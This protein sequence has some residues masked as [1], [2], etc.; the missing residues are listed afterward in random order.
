[1]LG[2][3]VACRR[4]YRNNLDAVQLE[5]LCQC[6]N[7][8][9]NLAELLL[10]VIDQVHLVERKNEVANAHQCTDACVAA[11]LH[12]HALRSIDQNDCQIGKRCAD[13]HVSG[14][15]LMSRRVSN[16]KAAVVCGE[17]AICDVNRDALLAFCH[18][19]VQQQRI[20]NFAAAAANLAVQLQRLFLIR[21][22]LLGIV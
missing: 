4:R 10:A 13:R 9:L 6:L 22:Q 12:K 19:T 21:V 3:V 15:L 8:R 18:Q 11:G 16:D 2:Q 20:I 5:L 17:V 14:V 1:M 7:I